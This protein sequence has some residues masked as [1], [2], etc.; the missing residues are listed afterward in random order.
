MSTQK[1][2]LCVSEQALKSIRLEFFPPK[3]HVVNG[4][5]K[6]G[7]VKW[8][9]CNSTWCY[10]DSLVERS[11][12]HEWNWKTYWFYPNSMKKYNKAR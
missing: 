11:A 10:Q 1:T 6:F 9:D 4:A 2:I 5:V 8:V 3:T 7:E 12:R